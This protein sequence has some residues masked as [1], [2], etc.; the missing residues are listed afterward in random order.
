MYRHGESAAEEGFD[1]LTDWFETL[2][3]GKR[4][5]WQIQKPWNRWSA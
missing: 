2:Q 4:A 5:S 3:S 1:E